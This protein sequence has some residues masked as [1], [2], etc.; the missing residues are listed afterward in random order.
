VKGGFNKKVKNKKGMGAGA[1]MLVVL[2]SVIAVIGVFAV[3][4][5]IG[6]EDKNTPDVGVDTAC[7]SGNDPYLS[8]TFA[9]ATDGSQTLSPTYTYTVSHIN[10]DGT[11]TDEANGGTLTSGSS[12][13]ILTKYDKAK[14]LVS[15]SGYQDKVIDLTDKPL[16]CGNNPVQGTLWYD[17]VGAT[18]TVFNSD[19]VKVVDSAVG[20]S[21]TN[22]T[23]STSTINQEIRVQSPADESHDPAVI[24][25]EANNNSKVS[26][27]ELTSLTNGVTVETYS[28]PSGFFSSENTTTTSY[29]EAWLVKGIPADGGIANFNLRIEPTSGQSTQSSSFFLNGYSLQ[30]FQDKDGLFK[31]VADAK[32]RTSDGVTNKFSKQWTDYDWFHE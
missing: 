21:G 22:E 23:G 6:G 15:L 10:P 4:Q 32:L 26:D 16:K 1:I 24:T 31:T 29:Y 8:L 9:N 18:F 30:A 13:T 28:L 12:G 27:L 5:S 14:V 25:I 19:G 11:Y 17:S 7:A 20:T 3:T 2:I